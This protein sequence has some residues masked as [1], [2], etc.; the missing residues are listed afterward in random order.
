MITPYGKL[1]VEM[2]LS[3]IICGKSVGSPRATRMRNCVRVR[4][5]VVLCATW[6]TFVATIRCNMWKNSSNN[7]WENVLFLS[8]GVRYLLMRTK[9]S[10]SWSSSWGWLVLSPSGLRLV[11]ISCHRLDWANRWCKCA[12]IRFV[13]GL[14]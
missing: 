5:K 1:L 7:V 9:K 12:Y 6:F 3:N 11:Y 2:M 14:Y 4:L 10:S 8:N 13:L